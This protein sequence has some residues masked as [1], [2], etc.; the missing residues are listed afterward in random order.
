[1][2]LQRFDLM[3]LETENVKK[4]M[5]SPRKINAILLSI[6]INWSKLVICV[7]INWQHTG[8]ISRKYT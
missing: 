1:M 3:K 6:K 4:T 8:K 2:K 7:D 5:G